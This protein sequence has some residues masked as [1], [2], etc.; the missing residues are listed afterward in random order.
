MR[1]EHG[2]ATLFS[3]DLLTG[4]M[5]DLRDLGHELAPASD[6]GPGIR[7]SLAPDG[8]SIAY[9]VA[10]IRSTIWLLKGFHQPSLLQRVFA[11]RGLEHSASQ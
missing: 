7:F 6:Y 5:K 11:S 4:K 8:K 9:S 1:E 2:G 3:F 10:D